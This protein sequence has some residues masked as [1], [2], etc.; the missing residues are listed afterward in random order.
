MLRKAFLLVALLA[1]FVSVMPALA[2]EGT[3]GLSDADFALY[4][5]GNS[6][7]FEGLAFDYTFTMAIDKDS[8]TFTGSGVSG[9]N[10]DGSLAVQVTLTGGGR[11]DLEGTGMP[12]TI[13]AD[14]ELRLIGNT[15]YLL[16]K[17]GDL[18]WLAINLEDALGAVADDTLPL[19][20]SALGE[21]DIEALAELGGLVEGVSDLL[22]S[23]LIKLSRLADA[24]VNGRNTAHFRATFDF[25]LLLKS[26]LLKELLVGA[27]Q[28]SGTQQEI[29]EQ[30]QFFSMFL[31]SFLQGLNLSF[32]QYIA[33]D[34]PRVE[35]ATLVFGVTIPAMTQDTTDS[36]INLS[37]DVVM[38]AYNPPIN[39][40]VPANFTLIDPEELMDSMDMG[41]F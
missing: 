15:L 18:G 8:L 35:R 27:G 33:T 10:A 3:L 32:D 34:T 9:V 6:Y 16:D 12:Q 30:F 31:S 22:D 28:L 2:Q 1:L 26:D 38:T 4:T 25:D 19:D 7:E 13:N 21:G 23:G 37:L 29:D 24:S 39:V 41:G 11:A 17:T 40:E 14:S 36:S 5:Q 20:P